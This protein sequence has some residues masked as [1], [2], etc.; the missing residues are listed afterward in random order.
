M[1]LFKKQNDQ[2]TEKEKLKY[3][4]GVLEKEIYGWCWCRG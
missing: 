1:I 3:M 2:W 4:V